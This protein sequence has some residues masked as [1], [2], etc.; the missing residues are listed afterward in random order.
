M[1]GVGFGVP[2]T[3]VQFQT[4]SLG[5]HGPLDQL[6]NLSGLPLPPTALSQLQGLITLTTSLRWFLQS[7]ILHSPCAWS[8]LSKC[9]CRHYHYINS[10]WQRWPGLKVCPSSSPV[11]HC[12][13]PLPLTV[14]GLGQDPPCLAAGSMAPSHQL[15]SRLEVCGRNSGLELSCICW[16]PRTM[17]FH[18][19]TSSFLL[20]LLLCSRC[21][22]AVRF[23][24]CPLL[25]LPW[26]NPGH[27]NRTQY[28]PR[29]VECGRHAGTAS[30]GRLPSRLESADFFL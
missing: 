10:P 16:V 4:A 23:A 3:W 8:G 9:Y 27:P 6:P 2:H 20:S 30:E 13:L 11:L 14:A 25:A 19:I 28:G 22:E 5:H 24:R 7:L 15:P 26:G 29:D 1:A 17:S 18:P 12:P 21:L